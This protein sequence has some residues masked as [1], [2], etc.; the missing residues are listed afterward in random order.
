MEEL[1][2][3]YQRRLRLVAV[4]TEGGAAAGGGHRAWSNSSPVFSR[5]LRRSLSAVE[6]RGGCGPSPPPGEGDPALENVL[7]SP[8][9][10]I[11]TMWSNFSLSPRLLRRRPPS[12]SSEKGAEPRVTLPR[13]F[14]MTLREADK[15]RRGIKTRSEVE[16]ENAALRRQLDQLT[17][18]QRKF[19]ASP[20][21]AHVYEA[22][23]RRDPPPNTV[24]KPFSFLE[25][26]RL[27]KER[28]PPLPPHQDPAPPFRAKPVP[29]AVLAAAA[30]VEDRMREEQLYRAIKIQMRAQETLLG[31]ATP[32]GALAKRLDERRKAK[33]GAAGGATFSHRPQINREVPDYGARF[34]RFQEHLE[35]QRE[36]RPPTACQPFQ[37]RTAH[38]PSHRDRILA[39]IQRDQSSPPRAPRWPHVPPG[40]TRTPASSLCSSPSG[41]V[42]LLPAK[43]TDATR[44]R[45]QAV[46]EVLEQRR[47][48]E[49]EEERR[50]AGQRRRERRLQ[51]EV[52]RRAR[53]H[54]P[55]LALAQT[56]LPKLEEF[57]RQELQRR[58]EYQQEVLE[59]QR[60]VSGRPLLLEQVAQRN[61]KQAAEKRFSH[62][63]GGSHLTSSH[64][65]SSHLTS[66]HLTSSHL[67]RE[68]I[69]STARSDSDASA[70]SDSKLSGCHDDP[71]EG[72]LP[73][74][75]RKVFLDDDVEVDPG[76]GATPPTGQ[77]E[78]G[79][80][81]YSDDGGGVEGGDREEGGDE[82][83]DR[84]E[85]GD[86]GGDH[87]YYSDDSD[88]ESQ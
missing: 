24:P 53:A 43:D 60:R 19:R 38:I 65:T 29:R 61:A 6:L 79:S 55:H 5:R 25:R 67:T 21:P 16:L 37:L 42:E 46:R 17:E 83:G 27:K 32:P 70:S 51:R 7:V 64:L 74:R 57:R 52:S 30:S 82:G 47:R 73:V 75:Y 23:Q 66:S 12:A 50:R 13:P 81:C 28:N 45:H 31:A 11:R 71:D 3:L 2:A 35:R 49:E 41:S 8:R 76:G 77:D 14:Q 44:R 20:A 22:V 88:H 68:L 48:A 69:G 58:R 18:R 34:R 26:E 1:E 78:D 72:S 87:Q 86:K 62:A 39:D 63:L 36:V 40:P 85:G 59:R 10:H 80:G 4:E 84:E 54:D 15:K 9:E 56:H 33:E